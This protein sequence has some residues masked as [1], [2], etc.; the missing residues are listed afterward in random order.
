[1]SN[2]LLFNNIYLFILFKVANIKNYI[3]TDLFN[4]CRIR[5]R[6]CNSTIVTFLYTF[7]K[8]N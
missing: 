5:Y 1:M 8:M 6:K 4:K 2:I 7:E 3:N